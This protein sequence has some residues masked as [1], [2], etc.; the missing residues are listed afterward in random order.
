M[1]ISIT[2]FGFSFGCS[3]DYKIYYRF[4]VIELISQCIDISWFYQGLE[5][6]KKTALRNI[7]VKLIKIHLKY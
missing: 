7:V 4:L 1:A 3:Q 6:F 5:N 2:I